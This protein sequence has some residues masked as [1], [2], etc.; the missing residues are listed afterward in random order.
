[1]IGY[2]QTCEDCG[3]HEAAGPYCTKCFSRKVL[4]YPTPRSRAQSGVA[5]RAAQ[6]RGVASKQ[7]PQAAA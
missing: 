5:V 2:E 7:S 4:R 3:L 1:M 6:K